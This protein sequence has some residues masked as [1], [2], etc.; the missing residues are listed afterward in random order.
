MLTVALVVATL[1]LNTFGNIC[2]KLSVAREPAPAR[3]L[4]RRFLGW[5]AAG[6]VAGFLGVLTFTWLLRRM[7]LEA[8]F[9][10]IQGLTVVGVQ[11][12]GGRM[13][14]G[15]RIPAL[16]WAGT[17]LLLGGIVLVSL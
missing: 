14:F 13:V 1:A 2:F 10:L 3:R 5:Q 15:E 17:G 11:L 12:F 16:A 8:A 9:P 6:N 4:V 7:S